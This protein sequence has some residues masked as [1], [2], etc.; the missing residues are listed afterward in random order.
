MI[1]S[2]GG[3]P[4]KLTSGGNLSTVAPGWTPDG[5]AITFN[6]FPRVGTKLKGVQV[7]D[8]ATRKLSTFPGSE[9]FYL[10]SWSPDGKYLVAVAQNPTRMMIY[11]VQT[12]VWDELKKFEDWGY[13]VWAFDSKSIFFAQ[14]QKG[15]GIYRLTIADRKWERVA[16]FDGITLP[17][18]SFPS[19]TADG[20]PAIMNDTSV[21]QI[22]S[23]PWK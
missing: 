12:Q 2:E 8:L 7:L 5:K 18:E 13:W 11:N 14:T 1:S 3:T 19:L 9:G 23:L 21:V 6:E 16:T 15:K 10:G 4:E 20:R 17:T 22:Y